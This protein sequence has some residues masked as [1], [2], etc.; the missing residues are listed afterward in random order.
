MASRE[1]TVRFSSALGPFGIVWWDAGAGP[2]IR[3]ILLPSQRTPSDNGSSARLSVPIRRSCAPVDRLGE[4]IQ[5]FL[6]GWAI[7]FELDLIAL[8][9]CS[10]FQRSVLV[11]EHRIPRG[12]V[13]TYG[14][15]ARA[16]GQQG[17]ARAVG[18]AL[19]RNPFPI[20]IPCHRA[21]RSDGELGGYQGGVGMKR[22]L[23]QM[24]GVEI[25]EQGRVIS[26]RV[27]Y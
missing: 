22:A 26:G 1:Y 27:F 6:A 7:G 21:I 20:V 19:A 12:W 17:A 9:E 15:I 3:R 5:H 2:R 18:R 25:S 4:Q 10:E 8:E 23:L 13:S 16:L 14:R 11:A 24:E